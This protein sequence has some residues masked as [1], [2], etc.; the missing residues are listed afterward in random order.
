MDIKAK[1]DKVFLELLLKERMFKMEIQVG[2][3]F[4]DAYNAALEFL[5]AI[6]DMAIKAEEAAKKAAEIKK[7]EQEVLEAVPVSE[8]KTEVN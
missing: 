5:F 3:P 7:E 1:D 6:R 8:V 2:T 4:T